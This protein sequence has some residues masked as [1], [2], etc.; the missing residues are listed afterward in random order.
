MK[1]Q[2][3]STEPRNKNSSALGEEAI[4]WLVRL[5]SG[6]SSPSMLAAFREWHS[7]SPEHAKAMD[8]ARKLWVTVGEALPA[9]LSTDNDNVV[10]LSVPAA[11]SS[12]RRRRNLAVAASVVVALAV[13]VYS[14]L[15][16][17]DYSTQTGEQRLVAMSDGSKVQ[18]DTN[19]ALNV[20]YRPTLRQVQLAQGEAYFDVAHDPDK[21]FVIDAGFGKVRVLGTAFSIRRDD[22]AIWVTVTRG[23]VQVSGG[24]LD[25]N[26]YLT[27]NEQVRFTS[28]DNQPAITRLNAEQALSWRSGRLQFDNTS[29]DDV[30][31]ALKR[32]DKRY[33]FYDASLAKHMKINTVV[34]V[35]NIN[36]WLDGLQRVLPIEVKQVGPV[37]WLKARSTSLAPAST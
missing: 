1:E 24:S 29:L 12:G 17:Y 2:P 7:Q 5:T 32:Y 20:D 6:E 28:D 13:G 22:N 11:P 30:L 34:N 26:L 33:W 16:R 9:S 10:P 35:H 19:T 14:H 4:T 18:L 23:R 3:I 8:E 21:A 31:Q 27:A 25:R 15:H 36:E 37:I